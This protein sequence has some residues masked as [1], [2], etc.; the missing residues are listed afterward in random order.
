MSILDGIKLLDELTKTDKENLSLF[1]QL[2][3]LKKGEI[4]FKEGEEAIAMYI[5]KTGKIEIRKDIDGKIVVLGNVEA[6]E[7]LGEM[8]LFGDD[9]KRMATAVAIEEC[10]LITILSFSI[11]D[12]TKKYPLLYEKIKDIINDRIIDNK[13]IESTMK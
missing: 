12:L 13:I 1:C 6:E 11:K 5:L 8:A 10:E 7:I 3:S 9:N 4:I 2:K